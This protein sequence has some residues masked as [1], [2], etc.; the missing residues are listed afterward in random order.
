MN[1]E[2][3]SP[4]HEA[5]RAAR[6]SIED[7]LLGLAEIPIDFER[8]ALKDRLLRGVQCLYTVLD[9]RAVALAHLDGL[10][11]AASIAA[12]SAVLLGRAGDGGA[13][14]ERAVASLRAA[15]TTLRV[16]E[17]AVAKLQAERRS[18]LTG[19]P[20]DAL[21]VA[22]PLRASIGVPELHHL[23]RRPMLP[24]VSVEP[25]V[26]LPAPDAP[27]APA[28][29]PPTTFAALRALA[30]SAA[31]GDLAARVMA[32]PEADEAPREPPLPP[33]AYEPA[34]D[35]IEVLRRIARDCLE[36]I[37]NH[38]NLRKPNA[39]ESWLDQ[40]PFEQQ[41]LDNLDAFA[42]LGGSVLPQVSLFA[43][44]ARAPD[45]ERAFAVALTLGSIAGSDTV[46]AAVMALKQS[47][48]ET[49]PGW[50]EGLSLAPNPAVDAAMADLATG[51]K[52]AL[53]ALALDV[54]RARGRTPDEV[55]VLLLDRA[56]PEIASRVARALATALPRQ[57]AIENLDRI[58]ATTPD[59]EAFLAAIE[60]LLRRG[61][62][63][64]IDLLRRTID[65]SPSSARSRRALPLL[66][67]V[68]RPSDLERLLA[69]ADEAPTVRLLR[70][71][72]RFGHVESLGALLGFLHHDDAEVVA[73]AA[74]ALDRITGAGQRV[75]VEEP[76]EI[77]LPPEA[78]EAGGLPVPTRRVE[79]VA[80]DP[81]EWSAWVRDNARRLDAK[82]KT[83]AGSPFTPTQ[84]VAELE[85]KET[86]A[87]RREEAA[88][89][90][91]LVTGVTSTFSPHDWV[92]RQKRD[93][94][95]LRERVSATGIAPGGWA[96]RAQ[97][98]E[99]LAAPPARTW[100][101]SD[102]GRAPEEIAPAFPSPP[103]APPG[104][105]SLDSTVAVNLP[106]HI[107]ASLAQ[108]ALPFQQAVVAE[109]AKRVEAPAAAPA[110]PSVSA[111]PAQPVRSFAN[112][113]TNVVLSPELLARLNAPL[114]FQG[115]EGDAAPAP[116]PAPSA[117]APNVPALNA[118]TA[119]VLSP[120]LLARFNAPLPFQG[121]E[122][123]APPAPAP[124]PS[125]GGPSV[126]SLNATTAV[127]LS[128]ELLARFNAPLP[129]QG[130]EGDAA[131]ASAHG[132]PISEAPATAPVRPSA[133]QQPAL[134]FAPA[135]GATVLSL[136]QHASLCAELAVFPQRQ[137]VIFKRY[138]LAGLRERQAEDVAWRERLQQNAAAHQEWQARYRAYF[139]YWSQQG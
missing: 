16:A 51:S 119:V 138:G 89:E 38:R 56:E 136:E 80:T 90:L 133:V 109:H 35:E 81:A 10:H 124:A 96:V 41:L 47:A 11:E 77:E 79:R 5:A 24:H 117:D 75:I 127:V 58:C 28:L 26:A 105:M 22:R 135:G 3:R 7:A 134:P 74:E 76:W 70:G 106:T 110:A 59:D 67:L 69:A 139:A 6:G 68:G 60:S 50:V 111:P 122:G 2:D 123:D 84:I 112:A 93:L 91:A 92:A 8:E 126:P 48:P 61:H 12:E 83:R 114:P 42:A 87:D 98:H 62:G 72:G 13:P 43:A 1:E 49:H 88:L 63:P 129:F 36:D 104:P 39:V 21:L 113:T 32:D 15:E 100:S 99:A 14:L 45:P 120:E 23:A 57:D 128:P 33:L 103:P 29:T 31:S 46:G 125:A 55:V 44:E 121:Q 30:E 20:S 9:T 64:A 52:P 137:E 95:E 118:T 17:D 18:E 94:A 25:T 107:L 34:I 102:G 108:G 97:R 85:A 130:Q 27:P 54:L 78:A 71:L 132:A 73:A 86:P 40:A 65:A 116:A 4:G 37:A 66:C 53:T 115:K 101:P 131:P 19:G 82:L